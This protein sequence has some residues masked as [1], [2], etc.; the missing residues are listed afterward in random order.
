[1]SDPRPVLGFNLQHGWTVKNLIYSGALARLNEHFRL[2]VW[3]GLDVPV[4]EGLAREFGVQ[5]STWLPAVQ[6]KE[7]AARRAIRTLEKALFLHMNDM[8]TERINFKRAGHRRPIWQRASAPV[9]RLA[10]QTPAGVAAWRFARALRWRSTPRGLYRASLEATK[11]ALLLSTHPVDSR[12][13]PLMRDAADLGIPSVASV[14]SWD[15]I[16][17]KGVILPVFKKVLVWNVLMRD[18]ILNYYRGSFPPDSIEPIGVPRFDIYRRPLPERFEREPFLR[19][20][21][22]DPARRLIVFANSALS[23]IPH[24]PE[25]IEHLC[26]AIHSGELPNDVQLLIRCHPRDPLEI[27]ERFN[28]YDRVR[29]AFQTVKD[30]DVHNWLPEKDDLLI[31]AATL[32]H[33]VLN[34]NPGSTITLEAAACDIPIVSVG[35]DGDAKLS[36][37]E[38]FL[39]SYDFTHLALMMRY[40][41]TSLAK[42]RGDMLAMARA[43]LDNPALHRAERRTL[44]SECLAYDRGDSVDLLLDTLLRSVPSPSLAN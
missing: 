34:I 6:V 39:A 1:M 33:S 25:V 41:A 19:G 35:Y 14:A 31:L 23:S 9:V 24:Q 5:D 32:K 7:S 29:V 16:S 4:M 13:D 21:G 11:P 36:P 10:A 38:S 37:E 44:V 17:S 22:L 20:L 40:R 3:T 42:S 15:N 2:V 43:Y 18:E 8:A 27:Y 12:E 26:N 28:K 30:R